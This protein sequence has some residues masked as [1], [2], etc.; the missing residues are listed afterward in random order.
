MDAGTPVPSRLVEKHVPFCAEHKNEGKGK[1][2]MLTPPLLYAHAGH[3]IG[4][5][6]LN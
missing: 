3:H 6:T 4:H 2:N 5:L 1:Y